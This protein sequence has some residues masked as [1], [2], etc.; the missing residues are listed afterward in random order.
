MTLL[1]ALYKMVH[2]NWNRLSDSFGDEKASSCPPGKC[3]TGKG[4]HKPKREVLSSNQPFEGLGS[5][6]KIRG[7]TCTK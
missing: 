1:D 3:I 6:W 7:K 4:A 2:S 5:E